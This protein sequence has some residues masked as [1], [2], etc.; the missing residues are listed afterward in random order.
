MRIVQPGYRGSPVVQA[1]A[2]ALHRQFGLPHSELGQDQCGVLGMEA[3]VLPQAKL[4][5]HRGL[6]KAGDCV[7]ETIFL[8]VDHAQTGRALVVRD[9]MIELQ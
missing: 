5:E 2:Q 4:A 6:A 9:R 3:R 7:I 1:L 8:Q